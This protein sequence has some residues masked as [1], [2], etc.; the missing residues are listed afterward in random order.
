MQAVTSPGQ[1]SASLRLGT[2][3]PCFHFRFAFGCGLASFGEFQASG[4]GVNIER[5]A[6]TEYS[7]FGGRLGAEYFFNGMLGARVHGDLRAT[8]NKLT[9]Y[10]NDEPA[11]SNPAMSM[12][13]GVTL[14]A[15]LP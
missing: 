11:W 2:L 1:V 14:L 15:R 6:T 5:Q 7:A 3:V 8:P 12:S 13:F 10:L 4:G 9:L